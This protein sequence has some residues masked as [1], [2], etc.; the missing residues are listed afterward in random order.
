MNRRDLLTGSAGL[1]SIAALGYRR[2]TILASDNG[3]PATGADYPALEISLKDDGFVIP[4]DIQA[5]RYYVTVNNTGTTNESHDALGR[6]P[7]QVTD[8]QYQEWLDSLKRTDGSDGQTDALTWEDIEFVGMPDWPKA[9]KSVTGVID[10]QP[11]R[12]FLFDPFSARG[13]MTVMVSGELGTY[14]EPDS[15]LT[16]TLVDMKI[17]LPDAA[18]TSNP[19]RWKIE[20]TGGI[21]HEVAIVPVDQ[22]FTEKDLMVLFSLPEDGTPPAGVHNLDYQP[23][24]AIGI[25]ASGHTSWLDVQLEP[26]HYGA[27]CML[28]FGT[29][30]PHAM[31]GMYRFF[32]V[33]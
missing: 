2:G 12:Y 15:D 31:D 23:V 24:A 5:G 29:G 8:A 32:E 16:V 30:Y 1:A 10:L 25:L 14:P 9:G 20:N 22:E 21:S 6:I 7:D 27:F 4:D 26:G 11:G 28:P 33:K 3:T 18:A 17:K 19:V 13:Y